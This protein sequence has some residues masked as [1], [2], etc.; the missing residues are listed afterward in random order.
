MIPKIMLSYVVVSFAT[1]GVSNFLRYMESDVC[2]GTHHWLQS[3]LLGPTVQ[4]CQR[5]PLQWC[6]PEAPRM[7]VDFD[8]H[9][10]ESSFGDG[11]KYS[12]GFSTLEKCIKHRQKVQRDFDLQRQAEFDV[13]P[14]DLNLMTKKTNC[15]TVA[16][17]T[18][19]RGILQMISILGGI[20]FPCLAPTSVLKLGKGWTFLKSLTPLAKE[21]ASAVFHW[22]D[23]EHSAAYQELS[24]W[25]NMEMKMENVLDFLAQL[26]FVAQ[27][28]CLL[29][30][31]S[32][33][34]FLICVLVFLSLYTFRS[35][36]SQ[37]SKKEQA[38]KAAENDR[39]IEDL[40]KELTSLSRKLENYNAQMLTQKEQTE[41]LRRIITN[42]CYIL[43]VKPSGNIKRCYYGLSMS[44]NSEREST[45]DARVQDIVKEHFEVAELLGDHTFNPAVTAALATICG[46]MEQGGVFETSAFENCM[47]SELLFSGE[48]LQNEPTV[49]LAVQLAERATK[50]PEVMDALKTYER[51][52]LFLTAAQHLQE[53]NDAT[54]VIYL[55]HG[56]TAT[57]TR[58]F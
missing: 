24:A 12:C 56:Q 5:E 58:P 22:Y 44:I 29:L 43:E 20:L 27:L 11:T 9:P 30:F 14:R 36:N 26:T 7:T 54:A 57:I 42:C 10:V 32:L 25:S 6:V 50:C 28:T 52:E 16:V 3:M 2:S 4:C 17:E 46:M 37:G 40:K 1:L 13:E 47:P 55:A 18:D 33:C 39:S 51:S 41:I 48:E 38:A 34:S 8:Q 45:P 35:D 49:M 21:V 19:W 31:L 53:G 23:I 15:K